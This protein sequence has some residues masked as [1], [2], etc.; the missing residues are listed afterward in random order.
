MDD[1][2]LSY[3]DPQMCTKRLIFPFFIPL[4]MKTV[5]KTSLQGFRTSG[6]RSSALG[7]EKVNFLSYLNCIH[8]GFGR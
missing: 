4:G 1:L 7:E 3:V 8:I 2:N 6:E 5:L